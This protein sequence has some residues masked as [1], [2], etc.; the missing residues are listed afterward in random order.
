MN[1]QERKIIQVLSLFDSPLASE[2][3]MVGSELSYNDLSDALEALIFDSL[4]MRFFDDR[5][6]DYTYSILSITK[7][8][9]YSEVKKVQNEEARIRKRLRSYFEG[10]DFPDDKQRVIM[11]NIRQGSN[12]SELALIDLARIAIKREDFSDAEALFEEALNRNP[13]SYLTARIYA[14]FCRHNTKEIT[15]ALRLY[16]RA[17]KT[18]PRTG[19]ERCLIFRE[20]GLL[21]RSSGSAE[22]SRSA[23]EKLEIAIDADRTDRISVT[24]L[25]QC[26]SRSGHHL[27]VIELL[28]PFR[29]YPDQKTKSFVRDLLLKAYQSTGDILKEAT[30]KNSLPEPWT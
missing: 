3:L 20:W 14:E 1:K 19:A 13:R 15:K 30:L 25:A 26:L 17:S 23:I 9:V 24:A 11:R 6:N 7:V 27:R 28:E 12:D 22:S 18:A 4:V 21:L 29:D 8:F 2:A 10:Y 16:E 5:I